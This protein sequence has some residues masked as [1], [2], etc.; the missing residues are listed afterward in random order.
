LSRLALGTAQFGLDYGINN[1]SGRIPREA[2]FKI[3]DFALEHGIDMLD[4]APAYGESENVL[5]EY[6]GAHSSE[7]KI[8]SKL[9]TGAADRKPFEESIK[10][11]RGR[12]LY[13]YLIHD[14]KSFLKRPEIW[15]DLLHLKKQG[16][17]RKIGF[18]L[19]DPRELNVLQERGISPDLI[20]IPYSLFD[21]RFAPFLPGIKAKSI[22]IHVRSVFLQGLVFK[23]PDELIG[24]FQKIKTKANLLQALSG[25]A[26]VSISALCLDFVLLNPFVDRAVIGVDSLDNLKENVDNLELISTVKRVHPEL[27][28]LREDDENIILPFLWNKT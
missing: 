10:R 21:Q 8:V 12:S 19:Y 24:R 26:G 1:P 18:S 6:I 27:M 22:E 15:N 11:L 7:F 3:L 28:G 17:I 25:K 4:T 23:R 2:V 5:G 13:G 20:Q 14:F 9:P 16:L